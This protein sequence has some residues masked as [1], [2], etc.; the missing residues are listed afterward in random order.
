MSYK[1]YDSEEDQNEAALGLA[2]KKYE[3][4]KLRESDK[5]NLNKK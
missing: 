4:L 3:K 5:E 1:I 2:K